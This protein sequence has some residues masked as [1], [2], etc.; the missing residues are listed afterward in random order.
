MTALDDIDAERQRQ[1]DDEGW[2]TE[3]DDHHTSHQLAL[4]AGWYCMASSSHYKDTCG[5]NSGQ[6]TMHSQMWGAH[7]AYAWP[8][9]SQWFKPTTERR[10][11]VKAGALILAAIE[12]IDRATVPVPKITQQDLIALFGPKMPIEVV[13]ARMHRWVPSQV[14]HGNMQC[15]K[16]LITDLEARAIGKDTCDA[17]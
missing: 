3:H 10:D 9:D 5:L 11:L 17:L 4:A 8:F 14:G 1:I 6:N 2:S 12:R 7:A 15:S 13:A 16:C